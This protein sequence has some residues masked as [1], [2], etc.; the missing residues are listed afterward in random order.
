MTTVK[1]EQKMFIE[2]EGFLCSPLL[3]LSQLKWF[4]LSG[5]S[6]AQKV[7]F[8]HKARGLH[9]MESMGRGSKQTGTG[10]SPCL[11]PFNEQPLHHAHC[12]VGSG[13]FVS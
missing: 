2:V 13:D 7:R 6:F 3:F 10:S 11:L 12:Q 9:R 5:S 8:A 1:L 4:L